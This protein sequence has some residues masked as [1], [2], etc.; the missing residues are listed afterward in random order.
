MHRRKQECFGLRFAFEARSICAP[1]SLT[2]SAATLP[3]SNDEEDARK[4][5]AKREKIR[6][7]S[8]MDI[9]FRVVSRCR[10]SHHHPLLSPPDSQSN[11]GAVQVRRGEVGDLEEEQ[12]HHFASPHHGSHLGSLMPSL[13]ASPPPQ[14]SGTIAAQQSAIPSVIKRSAHHGILRQRQKGAHRGRRETIHFS[15]RLRGEEEARQMK[16]PPCFL[17]S[18]SILEHAGRDREQ[19]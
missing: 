3:Q 19:R 14:V 8:C 12:D 2:P 18:K 16:Q 9:E 6:I 7:T 4:R 5:Y 17:P 10:I 11:Q 13:S 1:R 15:I